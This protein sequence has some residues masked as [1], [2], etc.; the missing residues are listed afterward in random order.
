MR[1]TNQAEAQTYLGVSGG[2]GG[3]GDSTG[4]NIVTLTQTGTNLSVMDFSLVQNGGAFKVSL[5]NSGFVPTP[6]NI[7]TSPFRKAWLF[8]QQ[9]STGTC[10][11]T[12]TNGS[13]AHFASGTNAADVPINDTNNGAVT[14]YEMVTD[15][16]TN[17][18][19]HLSITPQSKRLP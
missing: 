3:G 14:I 4:T 19:V 18:L 17:G 15:P 13:F 16:F 6:T 12:F 2:G 1:T 5:T 11:V 10:L 8:V 9:P 7:A